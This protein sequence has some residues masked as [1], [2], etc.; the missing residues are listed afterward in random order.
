MFGE[1]TTPTT[2]IEEDVEESEDKEEEADKDLTTG[3][4][5]IIQNKETIMDETFRVLLDSSTSGCIGTTAAV[6]QA[7]FHITEEGPTKQHNTATG[8]FT[9]T[10][11]FHYI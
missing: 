8:I 6:K 1:T 3:I 10:S 4:V 5:I 2:K 7:G 11:T 9:T